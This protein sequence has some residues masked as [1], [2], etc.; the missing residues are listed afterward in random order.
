M[1]EDR[2]LNVEGSTAFWAEGTI[3][4]GEPRLASARGARRLGLFGC[5]LFFICVALASQSER[6][7]LFLLNLQRKNYTQ[8]TNGA[9]QE[10][11]VYLSLCHETR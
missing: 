7:R 2:S 3:W 11:M 10:F 4:R 6:A 1:R 9:Y 8:H 5:G